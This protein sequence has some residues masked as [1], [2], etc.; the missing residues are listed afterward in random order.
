L[1]QYYYT[2]AALPYLNFEDSP[3][4]SQEEFLEFCRG[5]LTEVDQQYLEGVTLLSSEEEC[6]GETLSKWHQ[7]ERSFRTELAKLRA[8]KLGVEA[9]G[10]PRI[11]PESLSVLETARGAM[12]E[13][14]PAAA[15]LLIL[16]AYWKVL[17]ELEVNH[18]FDLEKLVVYFLKLQLLHLKAQRNR[19][20]GTRNFT[21]LYHKIRDAQKNTILERWSTQ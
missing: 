1:A 18:F 8:T 11:I 21:S 6:R 12:N 5:T 4:I 2:L 19:E 10:I 20:E 13:S 14:S 15:E 17:E 9:E 3:P 16:R 7:W